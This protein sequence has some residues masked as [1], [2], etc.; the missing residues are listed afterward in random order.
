MTKKDLRK[1][2]AGNLVVVE[3]L[4]SDPTVV[5]VLEKPEITSNI[6]RMFL[7]PIRF[8]VTRVSNMLLL[9]INIKAWSSG[10]KNIF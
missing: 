8:M 2:K 1:L 10:I 9:Q 6:L 4:D 5:L 3:W 7:V